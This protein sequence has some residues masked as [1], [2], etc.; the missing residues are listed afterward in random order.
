MDMRER[1]ARVIGESY[2]WAWIVANDDERRSCLELADAVLACLKEPTE[3]MLDA[4][5]EPT[6]AAVAAM[7]KEG[8]VSCYFS[9]PI[10]RAMIDAAREPSSK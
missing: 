2:G 3:E 7:G 8:F 4:A 1:I 10:W 9:E 5:H 6:R